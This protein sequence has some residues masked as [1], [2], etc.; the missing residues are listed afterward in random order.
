LDCNLLIVAGPTKVIPDVELEKINKYLDEGGR[1]FALLNSASRDRL[2]GLERIL[3]RRGVV[4]SEGELRDPANSLKG[5]DIV[6]AAF[7]QHPV[8]KPLLGYYLDLIM[9]RPVAP[10][11]DKTANA[12][13]VEVLAASENTALLAGEPAPR[14]Q[15]FPLAVAVEKADPLGVASE[16]GSMRMVVVGDSYFL[17]N[18]AIELYSN[19]DFAE[20]A[21]N[22]L[23]DRS[24]LLAGVGS[25][26]VTEFR[27]NMTKSQ[28]QTVQLILLGAMPG[29]ILALGGLVWLRRRK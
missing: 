13:K 5:A 26:P 6:V 4:V 27:V 23:L 22:W 15:R 17:A 14:P 28:L 11:K 12:P 9:P 3:V 25:R 10:S 8:V 16:R 2:T 18:A 1:M 7:S 19:R 21:I 24:E 20:L 29:A